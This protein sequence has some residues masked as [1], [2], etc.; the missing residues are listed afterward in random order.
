MDVDLFE[1]E[2]TWRTFQNSII[3]NIHP[4]LLAVCLWA[5]CIISL[6]FSFLIYK[7]VT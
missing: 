2:A 5:G 3:L 6:F 7:I 4:D 1:G